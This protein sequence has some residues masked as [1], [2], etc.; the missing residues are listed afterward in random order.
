MANISKRSPLDKIV[1]I[2]K[3]NNLNPTLKSI[4]YSIASRMGNNNFCYP[5]FSTLMIDTGIKNRTTLVENLTILENLKIIWIISPRDGYKSNRYGIDFDLLV[6]VAYQCS[7]LGALDQSATRTRLVRKAYS[8][9]NTNKKLKENKEE[10]S[11]NKSIKEQK[12]KE[13]FKDL[14]KIVKCRIK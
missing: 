3:C 6:R 9:G 1:I 4:L 10:P 8:K 7:T 12:T 14:L 13:Q 5:S 11:L 2:R